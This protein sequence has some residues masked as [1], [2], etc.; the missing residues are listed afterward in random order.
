MPK[1]PLVSEEQNASINLR[2][3]VSLRDTIEKLAIRDHRFLSQE[4]RYLLEIALDIVNKDAHVEN[5]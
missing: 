2:I 5:R 3:P 1:S 4:V